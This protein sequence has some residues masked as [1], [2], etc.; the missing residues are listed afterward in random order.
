MP[1]AATWSLAERMTQ[2]K[3]SFGFYFSAHP[4]DRYRHLAIAHGAR[5]FAELGA[6]PAPADGGRS[7]AVMAGLVEA[8][9]WRTSA[10]GRRYLM[11]TLSVASGPLVATVF[12]DRI[13]HQVE[14]AGNKLG[15]A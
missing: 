11:A 6:L 1:T 5:S 14:D 3:E 2:E 8:A 13:A 12:D 9:R 10:R 15:Q 4:V 7:S